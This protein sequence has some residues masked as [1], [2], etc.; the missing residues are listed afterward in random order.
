MK[1]RKGKGRKGKKGKGNGREGKKGKERKGKEME[2]KWGRGGILF[3]QHNSAT[4]TLTIIPRVSTDDQIQN[5]PYP[6]PFSFP[7]PPRIKKT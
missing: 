2:G 7:F 6:F 5:P 3:L 1:G 4:M